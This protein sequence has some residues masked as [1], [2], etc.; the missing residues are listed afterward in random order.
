MA[1]DERSLRGVGGWLAF[2]ILTL[3][4]FGPLRAV[5]QTYINLYGDPSVALAYAGRWGLLQGIEWSLV[6]VAAGTSVFLGWRLYAVPVWRSVQLTIA[7][8]WLISPV[9]QL[10]DIVAVSSIAG[11]GVGALFGQVFGEII[12]SLGYAA[13]WTAYLLRSRRVEN[14]YARYPETDDLAEV[15]D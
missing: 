8:L 12:R 15:F 3:S 9:V 11:V 2:F 5:A 7:G 6:A 14:T 4:V 10:I 1:Y 13:I